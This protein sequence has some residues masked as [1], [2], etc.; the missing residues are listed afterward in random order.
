MELSW[1]KAGNVAAIPTK[2]LVASTH[3]PQQLCGE[4]W[5]KNSHWIIRLLVDQDISRQCQAP[6]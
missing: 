6:C 5:R 4:H 3:Q 1:N 2:P